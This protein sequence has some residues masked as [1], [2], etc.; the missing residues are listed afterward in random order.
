MGFGS[1]PEDITPGREGFI[2]HPASRRGA[3]G[4]AD[5]QEGA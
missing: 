3:S 4:A 2:P 1:P 5:R